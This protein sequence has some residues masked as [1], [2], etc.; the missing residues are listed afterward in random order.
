[1]RDQKGGVR[2]GRRAGG[3]LVV[4]RGVASSAAKAFPT[5]HVQHGRV[6][7]TVYTVGELRGTRTV[8][9]AV[10]PMGGQLQLVKLAET[11]D[12]MKAGASS[13]NS[14]PRSRNSTSN[15]R[16]SIS[17]SPSRTS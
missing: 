15:R 2:L 7:V 14:T 5:A 3:G 12:A 1:M 16:G 10:P 6:Q 4:L 13:W 17:F 11:G 8:Q 9:L